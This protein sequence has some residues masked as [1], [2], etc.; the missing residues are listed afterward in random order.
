MGYREL[1]AGHLNLINKPTPISFFYDLSNNAVEQLYRGPRRE[2]EARPQQCTGNGD[3]FGQFGS[4]DQCLRN[5]GVRDCRDLGKQQHR[6]Q[7]RSGGPNHSIDELPHGMPSLD[8]FENFQIPKNLGD[9]DHDSA[10]VR[11]SARR[12]QSRRGRPD[13]RSFQRGY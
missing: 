9:H 13:M 8:Q 7:Y 10:I 2:I 4:G 1:G 12:N 11:P 5:A 3:R 6:P